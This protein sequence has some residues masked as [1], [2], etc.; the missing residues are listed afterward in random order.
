MASLNRKQKAFCDEYLIDLN[1]KQAAIR[2]GY[3]PKTSEWIGPNLLKKSHVSAHIA[4]MM[5]QRSTRTQITADNVLRELAKLGF[6]NMEDFM[7]VGSDGFP[8]I[9]LSSLDRDKSAAI[10]EL[11]VDTYNEA[12]GEGEF[13]EVKKVKMKVADKKSAL[14]LLGRHLGIFERDNKQRRPMVRI[15]DLSG[16]N[17]GKQG[18]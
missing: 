4:E 9:D 8:R 10:S 2:A 17:R 13:R 3:S 14:E 16:G 18:E 12:V 15:V 11:T 7:V 6:S 1:A 5:Q